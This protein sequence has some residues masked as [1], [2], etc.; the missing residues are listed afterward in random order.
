MH[1]TGFSPIQK[2]TFDGF[3][4][5]PTSALHCV[6]ALLNSRY[7]RR[8]SRFNRASHRDVPKVRL[9]PQGLCAFGANKRAGELDKMVSTSVDKGSESHEP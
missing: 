9:I 6:L 2:Q 8:P 3:V 4:K 5:S 7:A 1:K